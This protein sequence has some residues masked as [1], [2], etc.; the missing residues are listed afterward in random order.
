MKEADVRDPLTGPCVCLA[1][2][3]DWWGKSFPGRVGGNR[4]P[5]ATGVEGPSVRKLTR[6]CETVLLGLG[7]T[8]HAVNRA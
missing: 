2:A 8:P 5:E 6:A 1:W 4:E 3:L 7:W